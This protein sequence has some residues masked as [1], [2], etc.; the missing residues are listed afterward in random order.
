MYLHW[1]PD[2]GQLYGFSPVCVLMCACVDICDYE[3]VDD[4]ACISDGDD[5][6]CISDGDS[7]EVDVDDVCLQQKL[8]WYCVLV[9]D[10]T[11][12]KNVFQDHLE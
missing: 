7:D 9:I 3:V 4:F 11:I 12:C 6:A 5:V 8:W 10:S 1:Q 2:Q